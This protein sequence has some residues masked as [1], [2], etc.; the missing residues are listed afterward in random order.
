MHCS[1]SRNLYFSLFWSLIAWHTHNFHAVIIKKK[2]THVCGTII[3]IFGKSTAR[4][5]ENGSSHTR[6]QQTPG[7]VQYCRIR[8]HSFTSDCSS[9]ISGEALNYLR[10]WWHNLI[11]IFFNKSSGKSSVIESIV[12]KSFLPRGTGIVTRRPLILQLVY[13]PK[14]DKDHRNAIDGKITFSY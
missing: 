2:P 12:G 9:R 7:C 8:C 3:D 14:E 5:V 1:L 11:I 6:N 10:H 4:K 13:C